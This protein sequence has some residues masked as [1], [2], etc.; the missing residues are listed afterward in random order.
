MASTNRPR[1]STTGRSGTPP[2]SSRASAAGLPRKQKRKPG[3]TWKTLPWLDVEDQR[4]A[5][6]HPSR[7]SV[8]RLRASRPPWQAPDA[9]G[10]AAQRSARTGARP[11]RLLSERQKA[12]RGAAAAPSRDAG[13]LL[14]PRDYF[15]RQ[16]VETNE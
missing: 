9:F 7:R 6:R 3:T 15:D 4:D 10:V 13:G 1:R 12:T 8:S 16:P 2:T 11:R 14:P 5:I